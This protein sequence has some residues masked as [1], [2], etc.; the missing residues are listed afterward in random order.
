MINPFD[1]PVS[2]MRA[3]LAGWPAEFAKL[4]SNHPLKCKAATSLKALL[5]MTLSSLADEGD[6]S[7]LINYWAN[8]RDDLTVDLIFI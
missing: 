8:S 2:T 5:P 3:A 6:V 7:C 4:S 1:L